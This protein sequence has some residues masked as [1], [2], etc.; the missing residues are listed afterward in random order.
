MKTQTRS[1]VTLALG[2]TLAL[3][4]LA[5]DTMKYDPIME[6]RADLRMQ[7]IRAQRV[8]ANSSLRM[9]RT[10]ESAGANIIDRPGL[11]DFMALSNKRTD[12]RLRANKIGIEAACDEW[13]AQQH[14]K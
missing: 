3:P 11:V 6:K 13:V 5:Q 8:A 2:L 7:W 1:L 14:G 4:A 9:H 10:G 12:L